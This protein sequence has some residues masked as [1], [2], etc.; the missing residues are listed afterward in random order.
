MLFSSALLRVEI[1][2]KDRAFDTARYDQVTFCS[3]D[4]MGRI[5][6]PHRNV[7]QELLSQ[8]IKHVEVV[9]ISCVQMRADFS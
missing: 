3:V 1:A 4:T 8:Y 5:P 7:S 9:A 2:S 6:R